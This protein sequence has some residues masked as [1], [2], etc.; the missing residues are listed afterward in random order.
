MQGEQTKQSTG[1]KAC[2]IFFLLILISDCSCVIDEPVT[3][4]ALAA[5]SSIVVLQHAHKGSG[6]DLT[7]Q[8]QRSPALPRA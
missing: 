5:H 6:V 2:L 8:I 1:C 3:L 4:L 7:C